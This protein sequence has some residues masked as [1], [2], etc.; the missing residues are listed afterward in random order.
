MLLFILSWRIPSLHHIY[1]YISYIIYVYKISYIIYVYQRCISYMYIK[2]VYHISYIIYHISY[3][4]YHT[5]YIIGYHPFY[6]T[7]DPEG[8]YEFKSREERRQVRY[9][10]Y[11]KYFLYMYVSISFKFGYFSILLYNSYLA[12]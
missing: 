1:I 10:F 9:I 3:I 11:S 12:L 6:I 7:D 4:I 8:G 5:S 2:D